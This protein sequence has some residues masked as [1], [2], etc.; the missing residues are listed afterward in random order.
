MMEC[1]ETCRVAVWMHRKDNGLRV[2][3]YGMGADWM[4]DAAGRRRR[5][6]GL[7]NRGSQQHSKE[8]S[9]GNMWTRDDATEKKEHTRW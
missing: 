4:D 2:C 9:N 1:D 8:H 5:R 7:R 3:M 6:Y